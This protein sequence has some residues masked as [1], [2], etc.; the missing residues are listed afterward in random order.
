MKYCLDT[1]IIVYVL[2]GTFPSLHRRLQMCVPRDIAIPE[3]VR[4]ELLFGARKS[5]APARNLQRVEAVLAPFALLPF[6]GEAVEHYAD[7]RINLEQK[8]IPIGPNDL[9][10]AAITRASSC[11]LITRNVRE[12]SRVPQLKVEDWTVP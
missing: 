1:N 4:A 2:K 8:G 7:I 12:F 10:I 5:N 6:A 11:T 9:L 3:V